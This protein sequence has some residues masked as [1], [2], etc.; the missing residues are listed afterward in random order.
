MTLFE[1]L[2]T[3]LLRPS[4]VVAVERLAGFVHIGEARGN[5][6]SPG[7]DLRRIE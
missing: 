5:N 3:S 1:N 6:S 7:F 2:T 4:V